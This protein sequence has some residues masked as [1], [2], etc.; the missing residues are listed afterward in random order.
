[1]SE[2]QLKN[3]CQI[4]SCYELVLLKDKKNK[5][6]DFIESKLKN[7]QIYLSLEAFN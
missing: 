3:F 4:F 2:Q 5:I 7:V 6:F 1:M